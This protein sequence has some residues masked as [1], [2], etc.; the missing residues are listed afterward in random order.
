[1]NAARPAIVILSPMKN[2]QNAM[3]PPNAPIKSRYFHDTLL[4]FFFVDFEIYNEI[5][6]KTIPMARALVAVKINGSID[7]MKNLF[8]TIDAP[9]IIAVIRIRIVPHNSFELFTPFFIGVIKVIM[10]L[11]FP[12]V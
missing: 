3:L 1:M 4:N 11:K 9:D 5:K 12:S 8:T 2:N 10:Y 7:T 6:K